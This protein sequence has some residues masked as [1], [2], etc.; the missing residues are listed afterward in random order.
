MTFKLLC[1]KLDAIEFLAIEDIPWEIMYIHDNTIP[2]TEDLLDYFDQTYVTGIFLGAGVPGD[3]LDGAA[4]VRKRRVLPRYP[5]ALW[6]VHQSTPVTL[7]GEPRT[8]NQC[9]G[10]NNHFT[11]LVGY[12]HPFVWTMIDA[13]KK[14]D[15]VACTHI[16]KYLN[17]QLPKKRII[18]EY[19]DMQNRLR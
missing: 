7:D 19:K 16:A 14:E 11:H 15:P 9:E 12:Q 18:P 6:N 2:G 4:I 13:L 10:W 1:G 8:N 3:G 17:G 5:S